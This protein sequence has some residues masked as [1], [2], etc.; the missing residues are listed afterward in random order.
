MEHQ[1]QHQKYTCPMHPEIIRD[2]PGNCPL[3]GM[4]LEPLIKSGSPS[5]H[6]SPASGIADFKKLV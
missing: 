6:E 1:H 4:V 5:G 3:C 2:E